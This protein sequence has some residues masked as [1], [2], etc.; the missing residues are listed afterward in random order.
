MMLFDVCSSFT[1]VLFGLTAG[2]TAVPRRHSNETAPVR[3]MGLEPKFPFDPNTI[4]TCTYWWDN[5]GEIPC[6]DMPAEWGV[7]MEAFLRWVSRA[8]TPYVIRMMGD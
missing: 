1:A 8:V 4:S 3:L 5:N 6:A 7:S 2:V